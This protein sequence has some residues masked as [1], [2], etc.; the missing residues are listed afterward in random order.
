MK[1]YHDDLHKHI[2]SLFGENELK[3]DIRMVEDDQGRINHAAS[4]GVRVTHLPSGKESI[5]EDY[6]SQI[7]N[8]N[9]ALLKLRK[10]IDTNQ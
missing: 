6:E 2:R 5:C 3:I 1:N 9:I 10:L 4:V 8:A 7:Q